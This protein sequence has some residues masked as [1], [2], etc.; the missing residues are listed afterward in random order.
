MGPQPDPPN[1]PLPSARVARILILLLSVAF[2]VFVMFCIG[3][4]FFEDAGHRTMRVFNA[5][6]IIL[7]G[8][9]AFYFVNTIAK[10][11]LK[12][13]LGAISVS[14][15]YAVA[16]AAVLIPPLISQQE[17]NRLAWDLVKLANL[18]HSISA[19]DIHLI[20]STPPARVFEVE[21]GDSEA[22]QLICLFDPRQDDVSVTVRIDR[23]F[24]P[25]LSG[26]RNV[27]VP[28]SEASFPVLPLFSE[29]DN[30]GNGE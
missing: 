22:Y 20:D 11:E 9:V 6:L 26:D 5:L 27:V 29:E 15:G 8:P 24:V 23:G 17:E 30:D 21:T 25:E 19:E 16:I 13:L 28:R 18:K 1:Q 4:R 7:G 3:T 2:F 12:T 10:V 14:G